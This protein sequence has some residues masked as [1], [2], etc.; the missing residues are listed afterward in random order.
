VRVRRIAAAGALL[1]A[2]AAAPVH[3][4]TTVGGGVVG[5]AGFYDY[6]PS[7]AQS[8]SV[9][10]FTWCGDYAGH[11]TDTIF[12]E[13]ISLAGGAHV[14]IAQH[15]VLSEGAAGT[16]D[17][18]FTCNPDVVQGTFVNP[19]GNGVTYGWALYYVGT[20]TPPGVDNSIGVAFSLDGDTW[21]KDPVP[22]VAYTNTGHGNYG[23]GQPNVSYVGGV[24][25]LLYEQDDSTGTV[26]LQAASTD[27]VHFTAPTAVTA[28]GL[29]SPT[30]S[31]GGAAYDAGDGRWYGAFNDGLR[32]TGTTGGVAERGDY[33]VTL[34]ATS[35]LAAGTW[36]QL[37]TVDANLTGWE[38]N[39]LAAILR[40]GDG[41]V[42]TPGLPGVEL[43][44]ST[45]MPRAAAN[46]TPAQRGAS[47]A[48]NDW[49][50][51]WSVWE[52]GAPLRALTRYYSS[53]LTV[54]EVTTGWVDTGSFH[55]ESVLGHLY[56]AP[57]AGSTRALYGCV[58]GGDDY[59]VSLDAACES[60]LVLGVLGY[61]SPVAFP[62][63]VELYR[64]YAGDHFV[65][66][67][68]S[69]EGRTV[70]GILGWAQ[71]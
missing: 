66:T 53:S 55:Q 44:A 60:Q 24:E 25:T 57:A 56:E 50:I 20:D 33:G 58:A 11:T 47:A 23:L 71:P 14:T 46:A 51:A 68:A 64:C 34:Y 54:H 3:A 59:L 2:L 10:D 36:Q 32:P 39:F 15:P 16:W 42:Y 27:G 31:W 48:F 41:T 19:L 45:S 38:S 21:V 70:E 43:Y 17:S 12:H 67:S 18:L 52:P 26:H 63:G 29:P 13:Q 49:Q 40:N 62:G 28:S 5:T 8:G 65:S 30:P 69:C 7:V 4:S 61:V 35:D 22:A 1:C 37:D 6:S 9:Q